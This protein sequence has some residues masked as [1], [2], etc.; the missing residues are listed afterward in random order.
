MFRICS[1]KKKFVITI[2]DRNGKLKNWWQQ[3]CTETDVLN[4]RNIRIID[5]NKHYYN[6]IVPCKLRCIHMKCIFSSNF[7][8]LTLTSNQNVIF[9]ELLFIENLISLLW[10]AFFVEKM[11]RKNNNNNDDR[12]RHHSFLLYSWHFVFMRTAWIYWTW[13]K[14]I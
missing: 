9:E 7:I 10:W 1:M 4:R 5:S 12:C 13:Q 2:Y 3:M 8:A 11:R 6:G 14:V